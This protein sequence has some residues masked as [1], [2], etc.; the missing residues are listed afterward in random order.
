MTEPLAASS[1]RNSAKAIDD[2]PAPVRPTTP[3]Y[4]QPPAHH[5]YTLQT[6]ANCLPDCLLVRSLLSFGTEHFISQDNVVYS[7]SATAK[8]TAHTTRLFHHAISTCKVG[9]TDLVVGV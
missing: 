8:D 2:F 1:I 3:T 6:L 9:Q 7:L 4:E 5:T